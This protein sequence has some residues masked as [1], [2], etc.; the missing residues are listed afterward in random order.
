M[1]SKLILVVMAALFASSIAGLVTI[2]VYAQTTEPDVV[3]STQALLGSLAAFAG[4]L[5]IIFGVIAPWVKRW[6][7]KLGEGMETVGTDAMK[8]NHYL[9]TLQ[10]EVKKNKANYGILKEIV[11]SSAHATPEQRAAVEAAEKK[12]ADVETKI[13][14][15]TNYQR[16]QLEKLAAVIPSKPLSEGEIA[17]EARL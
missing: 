5:G 13:E 3:N 7:A 6:N 14:N 17:E 4:S 10:E 16:D 15:E 2:Q 1:A 8:V 12:I 9:L 11:L